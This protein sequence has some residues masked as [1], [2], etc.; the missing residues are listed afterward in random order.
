MALVSIRKVRN[1]SGSTVARFEI[2]SEVREAYL[3]YASSVY[4]RAHVFDRDER[5][6]A[7]ERL[8]TFGIFSAAHIAKIV[9]VHRSMLTRLGIKV[10]TG[11]TKMGGAFDPALLDYLVQALREKNENE[12]YG[13]QHIRLAYEGGMSTVVIARLLGVSTSYVSNML[14]KARM[15]QDDRDLV[16]GTTDTASEG[17]VEAR[18]EA[19]VDEGAETANLTGVWAV[20]PGSWPE[21]HLPYP[22]GVDGYPVLWGDTAISA[23]DPN[24]FIRADHDE[25]GYS[26]MLAGLAWPCTFDSV[27]HEGCV[28]L[29]QASGLID[30]DGNV[31]VVV[32]A[33]RNSG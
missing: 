16:V 11:Q 7:M 20:D 21:G 17:R 10:N 15:A 5:R 30:Q 22:D 12:A 27:G 28:A 31:V 18:S 23:S 4:K 26:H 25:G 3:G 29:G 24:A 6:E 32:R 33:A 19:G 2:D 14:K 9:R 13:I 1:G 8:A